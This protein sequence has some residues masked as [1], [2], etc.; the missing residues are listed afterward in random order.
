MISIDQVTSSR[1]TKVAFRSRKCLIPAAEF[2]ELSERPYAIESA[3]RLVLT[4]GGIWDSWQHPRT[5]DLHEGFA[6]ITHTQ[7]NGSDEAKLPTPL[8]ITQESWCI[9]LGEKSGSVHPLLIYPCGRE[10]ASLAN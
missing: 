3:E 6:I 5:G 8:I 4:F 10:I 1:A 9:W 2:Y 7:R